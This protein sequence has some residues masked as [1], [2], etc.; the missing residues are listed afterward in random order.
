MKSTIIKN[1]ILLGSVSLLVACGAQESE[2]AD[3]HADSEVVANQ[4]EKDIEVTIDGLAEH[5]HTGDSFEL[6]AHTNSDLATDQSFEWLESQDGE[7]KTLDEQSDTLT[8]EAEEDG[9]QI[10]VQVLSKDGDVIGESEPVT[11]HIDD[12]HGDDYDSKRVYNGFFYNDEV[13]DRELSDW[14]GQWQSVHPYLESGA[15]DEVFEHKA[16]NDDS[17]TAEDYKD[18]YT[19]GYDT[20]IQ[21]ID[22]HNDS[23]TFT[24]MDGNQETAAYDY[25]GYEILTYERGNRGVRFVYKKISGEEAMP[26]YIQFSDHIIAPE[27]SSHFHLYWGDNRQELLDEVDHWPTY[28]P[29]S[30]SEQ[31]LVRDMLAH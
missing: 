13:A 14:E 7:F 25:D 4:P 23:F 30:C 19:V 27:E 28:Y 16:N 17:M 15:L 31:D 26:E 24:D 5:Y 10:K 18:Y 2:S 1:T 3:G 9:T 20:D 21:Y 11:I 29:E 8:Y 12:H 22:I 6:T